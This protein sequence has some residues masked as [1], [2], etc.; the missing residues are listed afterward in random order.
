MP[1]TIIIADKSTY[2]RWSLRDILRCHGYSVVGEAKSGS[3][4]I[5]L[6][7]Q[8][9]PDL[10]VMDFSI[11]EPEVVSAIRE[12]KMK[13]PGLCVMVSCGM[14]QRRGAVEALSAGAKD[15][16]TRPY[17]ERPVVQTVKKVIG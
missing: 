6:Y 7:D 11:S 17:S 1:K 15:L 5:A 2:S 14:G 8:F 4:A 13:Y 12:L 10:L 3:E 16:I 9:K